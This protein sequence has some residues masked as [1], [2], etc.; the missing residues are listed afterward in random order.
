MLVFN[1]QL[2]LHPFLSVNQ[3]LWEWLHYCSLSVWHPFPFK[4][5]SFSLLQNPL[6]LYLNL[7]SP[8]G[9]LLLLS[10]IL[11]TFYSLYSSSV[12]L[13]TFW[14]ISPSMQYSVVMSLPSLGPTVLSVPI[15][16]FCWLPLLQFQCWY[17]H[18]YKYIELTV[19]DLTVRIWGC[20]SYIV[21][22]I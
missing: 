4:L 9:F 17:R 6:C 2:L 18:I 16:I 12:T 19:A 7:S 21:P 8:T 11:R 1:S 5:L 22:A 10:S 3:W 20:T 14:V 13:L 15:S